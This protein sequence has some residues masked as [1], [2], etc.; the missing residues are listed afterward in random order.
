MPSFIHC[1]NMIHSRS[2]SKRVVFTRAQKVIKYYA[3][4]CKK[5]FHR[6]FSKLAQSGPTDFNLFTREIVFHESVRTLINAWVHLGS[7]SHSFAH[8]YLWTFSADVTLSSAWSDS[9]LIESSVNR[10]LTSNWRGKGEWNIFNIPI[11]KLTPVDF[12]Q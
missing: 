7:S 8:E 6:H 5:T 3:F 4:F 9:P 10:I 1:L 12:T 11:A 2:W